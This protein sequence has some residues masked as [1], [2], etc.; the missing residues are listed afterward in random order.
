[1]DSCGLELGLIGNGTVSA[2]LNRQGSLV[3]FCNPRFDGDPVFCSLL[4]GDPDR[5]DPDGTFGIELDDLEDSEQSYVENTAI[6]RTVQRSSNGAAL[7]ILDFCP[8]FRHYGRSF[9]PNTI[10]RLVR[11]LSGAP[12]IRIRIRPMRSYGAAP[13]EM[14][15]GSNHVRFLGSPGGVLRATSNAPITALVEERPFVL[16][17][18][19]AVIIGEDRSLPDAPLSVADRF[20][21]E[22]TEYWHGAVRS[23]AIPFEWQGAVIRAAIT[24]KLSVFEDTGAIIAAPTTSI[25]EAANTTRNWDY[26][27][28]WLRDA[29]FVVRALNRLGATTAMEELLGYMANLVAGIQDRGTPELQPVYGINWE[30]NLEER[31]IATLSG[32]HGMGPVRIGNDAYRQTQHDVYGGIV[33][34]LAQLVF[35][36]RIPDVQPDA[37]VPRLEQAAFLAVETFGKPDAGIWELRG[38]ARVHTYSSLMC[39]AA[40]DRL[41]RI[42]AFV[43]DR[44][45]ATRWR[46]EAAR[47]HR[48]LAEE[49]WSEK[50]G[51]FVS[52]FGGDALDASLLLMFEL[53]FLPATDPR[54]LATLEAVERDLVRDGFVYRYTEADDFGEPQNAFLVCAF[55]LIDALA[56]VGRRDEAR[57]LFERVLKCRTGLGLMAEHI[58]PRTGRMWGNF[59]QTYSMAGIINCALRLS[60]PW[61][62][63][64]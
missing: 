12:R 28:C 48:V 51:S 19:V 20:L 45:R 25:P 17:Q 49:A 27:F 31:E 55:W 37:L 8:R 50:R 38:A 39:W 57:E 30:P 22:T 44:E 13:C 56:M 1:M 61:E 10:V 9:R 6:L 5:P 63:A 34:A 2:L 7:E 54:M 60:E 59:P 15:H 16:D 53:G 35:D 40:C 42:A 41:A 33:L 47:M 58:D 24:L 29:Y 62:A 3:W 64:F 32:F 36:A 52:T 21:R 4:R 23:L 43:G 46:E 14:T 11:P 26:R 18:E